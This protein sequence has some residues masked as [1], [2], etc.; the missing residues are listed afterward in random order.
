MDYT[1]GICIINGKLCYLHDAANDLSRLLVGAILVPVAVHA[2]QIRG[3]AK[4]H[5]LRRLPHFRHVPIV[6]PQEDGVHGGKPDEEVGAV[7]AGGHVLATHRWRWERA[8]AGERRPQEGTHSQ[9]CLRPLVI[10]VDLQ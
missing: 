2:S 10:A 1:G 7:I 3:N 6:Q 9:G 8:A 4:T 5:T